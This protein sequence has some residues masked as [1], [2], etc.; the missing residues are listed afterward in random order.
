M[1]FKCKGCKAK[2][3]Q[4]QYLIKLID[5]LLVRNGIQTVVQEAESIIQDEKLPE[6]S[7]RYGD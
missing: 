2:D 7:L 5:N 3:E 6:G 4:I 1:I